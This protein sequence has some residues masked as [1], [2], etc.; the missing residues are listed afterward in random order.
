MSHFLPALTRA[1]PLLLLAV[2]LSAV[3]LLVPGQAQA[4]E[5]PPQVGEA[6][7][8]SQSTEPAIWIHGEHISTRWQARLMRPRPLKPLA[9]FAVG[10][11][12][13]LAGGVIGGVVG[14]PLLVIGMPLVTGTL[15]AAIGATIGAWLFSGDAPFWFMGVG[16][17]LGVSVASI[18]QAGL[19]FGSAA[20]AIT[21][22]GL[23]LAVVLV[24]VAA[25]VGLVLMPVGACFAARYHRK[26]PVPR[27][28]FRPKGLQP[29]SGSAAF[30]DSAWELP[31]WQPA[32]AAA[33]WGGEQL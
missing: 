12:F 25:G 22:I 18:V 21:I 6:S 3:G 33:G 31:A 14:L 26:H 30:I 27:V 32:A 1:L 7:E 8:W 29:V 28:R 15:G 20:A 19:L 9:A 17:A 11:G 13:G 24:G 23:P 16:A 2:V 5:A 10:A 4:A